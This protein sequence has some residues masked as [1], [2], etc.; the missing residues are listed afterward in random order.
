MKIM[1]FNLWVGG[2]SSSRCARVIEMI[3]KYSPDTIGLQEADAYWLN[4]L[5]SAFDGEYVC[6]GEGR[7]GKDKGEHN[8][9]LFKSSAFDA[10]RSGTLW[11][12]DTPDR[13][14]KHRNS[15]LNRIFTYAL[16]KRKSDGAEIMH[17]NTHFDHIGEQARIS[18]AQILADFIK[19]YS[20]APLAVT[21]DFNTGFRSVPYLTV[22]G[23]GVKDAY[24]QVSDAEQK[25]TFTNYGR[26]SMLIDFI[27]TSPSL[28]CSEY[29][30]C[31][32]KINGDFPS[33]HHPV[34]VTADI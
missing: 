6:V 17:I 30:V 25:M 24:S 28:P 31:D 33:D 21:G 26:D 11:L 4:A 2:K 9:I 3:K 5:K 12:S 27:F 1:T 32:E 29:K 15:S 34:Q 14:S 16:L 20:N 19:Q 7:D 10:V 22:E 18:Q 8:P 23:A 13:V